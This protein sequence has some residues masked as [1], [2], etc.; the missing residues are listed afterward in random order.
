M[1]SNIILYNNIVV[2][3]F[4]LASEFGGGEFQNGL[5]VRKVSAGNALLYLAFSDLGGFI[6][7]ICHQISDN[8][9][10]FGV[11]SVNQSEGG[12]SQTQCQTSAEKYFF[13]CPIKTQKGIIKGVEVN[14]TPKAIKN[15]PGWTRTSNP[16]I[17]SRMLRH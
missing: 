12:K 4:R 11:V 5:F 7:E 16:S 15:S 9:V 3:C 14:S 2:K 8:K 17:N 6:V 1:Y 10:T 13:K